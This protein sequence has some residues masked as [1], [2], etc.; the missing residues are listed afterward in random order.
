MGIEP[1][2]LRL[3][4]KSSVWSQIRKRRCTG[5]DLTTVS[6]IDTEILIGCQQGCNEGFGE[7]DGETL[8]TIRNVLRICQIRNTFPFVLSH[9]VDGL[10]L[11]ADRCMYHRQQ[12]FPASAS[13]CILCVPIISTGMGALMSFITL[14]TSIIPRSSWSSMWQCMTNRPVKS[15]YRV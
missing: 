4:G 13:Y 9:D 3:T 11:V 15:R 6:P 14:S 1:A 7:P 5:Y 2:Y 12:D 8:H 10:P